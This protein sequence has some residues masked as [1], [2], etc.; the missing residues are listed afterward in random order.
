MRGATFFFAPLF[1]IATSAF[2]RQ[3]TPTDPVD[4]ILDAF[5]THDVVAL[6]EGRHGNQQGSDLRLK[7]IRDPRFPTIVNDIMVECGAGQ[8][9]DIADRFTE[10]KPVPDTE[11]RLIWQDTTQAGPTCDRPIYEALFR[12]V[13]AVNAELP[14][15]HHLRVLLGDTPIDWAAIARGTAAWERT[16]A[17]PSKV[18]EQQVLARH[19]RA[20]II[21]GEIHYLRKNLY[22][23]LQ[24]EAKAQKDFS[25]PPNSIVSRLESQGVHV[26]SVWTEAS[27]DLS[28]LEP[29]IAHWPRP[30]LAMLSDTTLGQMPFTALYPHA[31]MF[32]YPVTDGKI[33]TEMVKADPKRSP[34][35]QD[36]FDALI[37]LGPPS[38][39]TISEIPTSECADPNYLSFR[40]T[41]LALAA[42]VGMADP[43]ALGKA[44]PSAK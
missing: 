3:A 30:S 36:E 19:R 29:G 12:T 21:Y 24:D 40:R 10:G 5:K 14:A 23:P 1:L 33:V 16:D 15:Q 20:L 22:W 6:G 38:A 27:I 26:F 31:M 9:Q 37:Y 25:A 35:I 17:F 2:A 39:I 34:R 43:T 18:V 4:G 28:A 44:C 13:R 32:S 42:K 7:L 11:L 8:H 41:R